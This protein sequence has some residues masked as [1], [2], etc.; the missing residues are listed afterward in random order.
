MRLG[1]G[2]YRHMLTADNFRFAKQAGATHHVAHLVD[3]FKDEPR[4]PGASSTGSG[5][6]VSDNRDRHWTLEELRDLVGA[7]PIPRGGGSAPG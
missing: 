7:T 5:W 2:L 1:L 4:L 6:G 3:Y